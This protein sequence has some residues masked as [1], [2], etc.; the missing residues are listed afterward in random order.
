VTAQLALP[1]TEARLTEAAA[2]VARLLD[3]CLTFTSP[4]GSHKAMRSMYSPRGVC[5]T[6]RG[7]CSPLCT[8]WH[9]VVAEAAAWLDRLAREE[10]R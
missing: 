3:Q 10:E 9:E 1:T 8:E 4:N 2:L 6:S 5:Q 7:A